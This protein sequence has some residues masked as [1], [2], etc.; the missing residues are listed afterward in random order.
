MDGAV[1]M[2]CARPQRRRA[3][4]PVLLAAAIAAATAAQWSLGF[5]AGGAA[6][7]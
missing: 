2:T 5:V 7:R 3:A 4:L 6:A 1:A